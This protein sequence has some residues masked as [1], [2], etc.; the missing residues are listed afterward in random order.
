MSWA[1]RGYAAAQSGKPLAYRLVTVSPLRLRRM[2][3]AQ[4]INLMGHVRQQP[5]SR[6]SFVRVF[7]S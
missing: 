1:L 5:R 7:G 6:G 3:E 4:R 2:F